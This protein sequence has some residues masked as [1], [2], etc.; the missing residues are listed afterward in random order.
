MSNQKHKKKRDYRR[1]AFAAL[2]ALMA[3]ALVLPMLTILIQPAGA[4]TQEELQQQIADGKAATADL[5]SQMKDLQGQLNSIRN[6]KAKALEQKQLIEQQINAQQSAIDAVTQTIAQYDQLIA[7]KMDEVAETEEK[8]AIQYE[9]FCKRVRVMEEMGAVSYLDILFGASSFSDLLDGA[10]MVGELME[11]DNDIIN[12]LVATRQALLAQQ[13]ALEN[14]RLE[15][16]TQK[17]ELE[18]HKQALKAN[19]AEVDRLLADIK[20]NEADMQAAHDAL[21][22]ESDRVTAEITKKQKELQALLD[23]GK[24]NFDPGTG[25]QWPLHGIYR[26]T[27]TFGPRIHPITGRPGNHTGTDIAAPKNTPIHVARGGV[28]T[29]STYGSSYGNYVVVQHDNGVST[30][31][32]HMNSRAVKEG[33]VVT[34]DQVIGYVGTTGSS[35]GNHLHLEFRVNG[36]RADALDYY[37][38][39]KDQFTYS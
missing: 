22:A 17:T 38:G 18:E 21:K 13:T 30:L 2:A 7:E 34:Q 33:D 23:A 37:P 11:Y 24:I 39:L 32:A 8:E 4:L 36:T 35:T 10:M 26:I 12:Q 9:N 25:W 31:Y 3:L 28:V 27:S 14:T 1:I 5:T 19:E 29:I 15:Q 16:Q 20:K 6:D